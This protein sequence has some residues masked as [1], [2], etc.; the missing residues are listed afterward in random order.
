MLPKCIWILWLQGWNNA[1]ELVKKVKETWK[2]HNPTWNIIE[3]DIEKIKIYIETEFLNYPNMTP[4]AAS[5]IIRLRI[6]SKYGGVWADSTMACL[7]PLD[8]WVHSAIEPS[9]LWMYHGRDHGRGPAS[10]FII[11]VSTSYIIQEWVKITNKYWDKPKDNFPYYW[12]D[13]LFAYLALNDSKFLDEW[14]KV[15]V[16][17]CEKLAQSHFFN[18][19]VFN[20][21]IE[22][23]S[24]FKDSPPYAVK[25]SWRGN[26]NQNTNAWYILEF[27]LEKRNCKNI[28]WD[29]PPCYD[30]AKFF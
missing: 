1:P 14:K 24:I 18:E 30:N 22:R 7:Y 11:S 16:L 3:L 27:A 28:K 12:M 13:Q 23:L 29:N 6:L 26:Y 17:D 20:Y 21:D 8:D 5:D 25:L 9:G 2:F 19:K 15:P 4:Q 10:W